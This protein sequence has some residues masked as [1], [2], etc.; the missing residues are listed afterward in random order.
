MKFGLFF[1]KFN[2]ESQAVANLV[3]SFMLTVITK[4]VYLTYEM[5]NNLNLDESLLALCLGTKGENFLNVT[6]QD[7][8]NSI[9][10]K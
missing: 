2:L 8:E 5:T 6:V 3:E 1:I 9:L 10:V 7:Y 4:G